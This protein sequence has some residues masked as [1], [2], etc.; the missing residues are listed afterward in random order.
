MDTSSDFDKFIDLI[1]KEGCENVEEKIGKLTTR[2]LIWT[3]KGLEIGQ[4]FLKNK[5]IV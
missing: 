3:D 4:I 2:G 1:K 5:E